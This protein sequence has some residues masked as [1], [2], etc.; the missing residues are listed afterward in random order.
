MKSR[1]HQLPGPSGLEVAM[2]FGITVGHWS[3]LMNVLWPL[4]AGL[5]PAPVHS[6]IWIRSSA[7]IVLNASLASIRN[8]RSVTPLLGR[9]C[10]FA[11]KDLNLGNSVGICLQSS[12]SPFDRAVGPRLINT[13]LNDSPLVRAKDPISQISRIDLTPQR[14]PASSNVLR[15][16][17]L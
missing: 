11:L 3:A 4:A 14:P 2:N 9:H 17:I 16:L 15:E 13:P 10:H 6:K 8:R 7:R 5:N 12:S 1:I